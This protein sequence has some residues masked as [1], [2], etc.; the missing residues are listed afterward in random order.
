MRARA[1]LPLPTEVDSAIQVQLPDSG[2]GAESRI[3]PA[4]KRRRLRTAAGPCAALWDWRADSSAAS[5][6]PPIP[7]QK[8]VAKQERQNRHAAEKHAKGHF[9]VAERKT[10]GLPGASSAFDVRSA[11]GFVP[12][13]V[14]AQ[15]FQPDGEN[16]AQAEQRTRQR[17]GK[18]G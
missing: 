5:Q 3:S 11:A 10:C 17:G 13:S 18:N 15:S 4:R 7:V 6:R 16:R 9:V 8:A 12:V 14:P 2:A 1:I